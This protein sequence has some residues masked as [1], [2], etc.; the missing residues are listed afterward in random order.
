MTISVDTTPGHCANHLAFGLSDILL[1]DDHVM[2]WNSTLV[3]VP[4]GSMADYLTS[5]D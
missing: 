3:S 5:P 4:D 1:S 2:G